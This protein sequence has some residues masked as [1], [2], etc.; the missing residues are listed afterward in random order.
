MGR[1]R[2][3]VRERDVWVGNCLLI[4]L[5]KSRHYKQKNNVGCDV[6]L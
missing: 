2:K 4:S 5:F 6:Y 3:Q 1:S